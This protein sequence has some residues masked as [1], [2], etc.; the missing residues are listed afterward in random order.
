MRIAELWRYPVKSMGGERLD[1][2]DLDA[3]GVHADRLWAIRDLE[4]GGVTTARRLPALMGCSARFAAAPPPDAGP[5]VVGE[6]VVTFPD[7]EERSS[8]DPEVHVR[9]SALTGRRVELTP[10]PPVGDRAAY[11][12]PLATQ[13]DIRR[14]FDIPD[15][16]PLP[17]LSMFPVR[18]LAELARYATPVGTFA[19]AYPLHLLTRASLAAM[20]EHAPGASFDSR[21]F[22]PSVLLEGD[23][24]PGLVENGWLGGTLTNGTAVVRAEIPT[25]RCSMPARAQPGLAAEPDVVRTVR[26]Q[27]DGCLGV[28]AEVA[29]PGR[30]AVGDEMSFAPAAAP[31]ALAAAAGRLRDAARRRAVRASGVVMPKGR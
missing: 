3:R 7:G 12:G 31:T 5:G 26:G 20:A 27:A 18:K 2:V 15:D 22:R 8:S 25:I 17:D 29:R 24:A 13:N 30:L 9:L 10:L 14:Q 6:V 11:R 19:D 4:L 28:Y 21:R 16:E 1:A 23:D